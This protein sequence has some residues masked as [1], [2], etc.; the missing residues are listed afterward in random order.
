MSEGVFPDCL[1]SILPPPSTDSKS[2]VTPKQSL[3]HVLSRRTAIV[4]RLRSAVADHR[5]G[6]RPD[7]SEDCADICDRRAQ[8]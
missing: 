8:W 7:D 1:S 4:C 6:D 5:Q 2:I 3:S